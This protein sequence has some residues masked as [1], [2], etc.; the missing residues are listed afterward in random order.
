MEKKPKN[1]DFF[2][3]TLLAPLILKKG[4]PAGQIMK[5][6]YDMNNYPYIIIKR[7]DNILFQLSQENAPAGF[8]VSTV[9]FCLTYN[10][11]FKA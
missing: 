5:E 4:Y 7:K 6:I 8:E 3:F 11:E 1:D 9:M 10:K 2:L